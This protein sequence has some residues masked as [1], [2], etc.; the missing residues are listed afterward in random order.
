MKRI[1]KYGHCVNCSKMMLQERV[2]DG[3][4]VVMFT[5]DYDTA[6]YLL[7]DGSRMRVCLCKQCKESIN[8]SCPKKQ[9]ELMDAVKRGWELEVYGL[10]ADEKRIDWDKE[11]ADKHMEDYNKKEIDCYA[12]GLADHVIEERKEK[13]HKMKMESEGSLRH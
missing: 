5:P 12:E 8:L 3:K 4:C 10:A 7:N 2:V 1:D 13:V 6:E 11:R 9:K